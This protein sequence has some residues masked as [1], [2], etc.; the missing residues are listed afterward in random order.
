MVC[1]RKFTLCCIYKY[2]RKAQG[3][4]CKHA[5]FQLFVIIQHGKRKAPIMHPFIAVSLGVRLIR[6]KKHIPH[7]SV[8]IENLYS[9]TAA[10]PRPVKAIFPAT[11]PPPHIIATSSIRKFAALSFFFISIMLDYTPCRLPYA[12]NLHA[13]CISSHSL[14]SIPPA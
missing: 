10:V 2:C 14:S 3:S 12:R 13:S 4:T 7:S 9:N 5:P 8:A 6:P 11:N 1:K